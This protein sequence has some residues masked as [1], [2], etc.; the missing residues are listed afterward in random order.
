MAIELAPKMFGHG[1]DDRKIQQITLAL[2]LL[3]RPY[4]KY[5]EGIMAHFFLKIAMFQWRT[6]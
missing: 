2:A 1:K 5:L 6:Q 3:Q 4:C